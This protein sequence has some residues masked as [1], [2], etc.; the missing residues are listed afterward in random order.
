MNQAK[1]LSDNH[2]VIWNAKQGEVGLGAAGVEHLLCKIKKLDL[3][4]RFLWIFFC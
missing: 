4:L 1:S 2:S 3:L